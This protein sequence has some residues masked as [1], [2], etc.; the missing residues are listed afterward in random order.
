MA[1]DDGPC[2]SIQ[3]HKKDAGDQ[4]WYESIDHSFSF[5]LVLLHDVAGENRCQ[6]DA[7]DILQ[8]A[9]DGLG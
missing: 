3:S 2:P 5:A 4:K 8:D 1:S 9:I 7:Y 6:C